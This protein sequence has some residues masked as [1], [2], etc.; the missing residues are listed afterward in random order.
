MKPRGIRRENR[1]QNQRVLEINTYDR[2]QFNLDDILNK[3]NV[4]FKE[5]LPDRFIFIHKQIM[6]CYIN[7]SSWINRSMRF[8]HYISCF[9]LVGKRF[10]IEKRFTVL[11][12]RR[13]LNLR[14][15]ENAGNYYNTFTQ[16]MTR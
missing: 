2:R 15:D 7:V 3:I 12:R 10:Y 5:E 4:K 14:I 9:K 13:K 11:S 1:Q 6:A 8:I 16:S